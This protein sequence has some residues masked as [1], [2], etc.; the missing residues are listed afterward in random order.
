MI[1]FLVAQYIPTNTNI[2]KTRHFSRN[3]IIFATFNMSFIWSVVQNS[4]IS[5]I[6]C[7]RLN[8]GVI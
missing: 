6:K 5:A 7:F 4:F 1:Q 2:W 3:I 8:V